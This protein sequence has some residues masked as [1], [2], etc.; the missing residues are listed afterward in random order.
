MSFRFY[1]NVW[2]HYLVINSTNIDTEWLLCQALFLTLGTG[3]MLG[4][5]TERAI[6]ITGVLCSITECAKQL[7]LGMLEMFSGSP[8]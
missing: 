3:N 1:K 2:V 4:S 8:Q 6:V 5:F 7:C